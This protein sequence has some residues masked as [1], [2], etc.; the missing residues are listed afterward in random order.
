MSLLKKNC[1]TQ[2]GKDGMVISKML[3]L[4]GLIPRYFDIFHKT[5]KHS[6]AQNFKQKNTKMICYFFKRERL[7]T[8]QP[9]LKCIRFGLVRSNSSTLMNF[10]SIA[11]PFLKCKETIK[12]HKIKAMSFTMLFHKTDRSLTNVYV[13]SWSILMAF[14]K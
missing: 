2:L 11:T 3:F 7:L 5:L 6:R 9:H 12:A 13:L 10:E 1:G 8:Q 4:Q 14:N